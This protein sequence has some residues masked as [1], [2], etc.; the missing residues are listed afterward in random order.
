MSD[1]GDIQEIR[2]RHVAQD[3]WSSTREWRCHQD[4]ETLLAAVD[5]RDTEIER[6][7]AGLRELQAKPYRVDEVCHRLLEPNDG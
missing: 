4:R 5:A 7:R 1:R 2:E 3:V 6:L